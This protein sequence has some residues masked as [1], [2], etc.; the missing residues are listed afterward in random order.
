MRTPCTNGICS[1]LGSLCCHF[2][3]HSFLL[4]TILSACLFV[5]VGHPFQSWRQLNIPFSQSTISGRYFLKVEGEI[6]FLDSEHASTTAAVIVHS[7][8]DPPQGE[9]IA[10]MRSFLPKFKILRRM[11][12]YLTNS[13]E[14]LRVIKAGLGIEHCEH[15]LIKLDKEMS[16]CFL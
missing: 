3:K 5:S 10:G 11:F 13:S 2:G 4:E 7:I 6:P 9:W 16:Q 12:Y 14:D 1:H 8:D 15:T